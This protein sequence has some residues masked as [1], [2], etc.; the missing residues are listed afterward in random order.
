MPAHTPDGMRPAGRPRVASSRGRPPRPRRRRI[1]MTPF[2]TA[3]APATSPTT[4][5]AVA[6]GPLGRHP[7]LFA[8]G[9]ALLLWLSF[10]TRGAW[11]LAWV[12]LVPLLLTTASPRRPRMVY[13]SAWLGGLAFWLPTISWVHLAEPGVESWG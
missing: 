3:P 6:P 2:A 12:A 5:E 8:L 11:P 9:S 1:V 13:A 4:A 10:P 7:A